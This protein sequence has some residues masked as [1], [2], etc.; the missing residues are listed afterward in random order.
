M[1][2]RSPAT[3]DPARLSKLI[4]LKRNLKEN[5]WFFDPRPLPTRPGAQNRYFNMNPPTKNDDVCVGYNQVTGFRSSRTRSPRQGGAGCVLTSH[6][7]NNNCNDNRLI[8]IMVISMVWGS[9]VYKTLQLVKQRSIKVVFLHNYGIVG[10]RKKEETKKERRTRRR[11]RRRV[12]MKFPI[13]YIQTP[14]R[15]LRGCYW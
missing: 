7:N 13:L 8:M 11:R 9:E 1:I 6:S 5:R 12:R 14:D 2:F 3:P 4:L 10:I 15:P